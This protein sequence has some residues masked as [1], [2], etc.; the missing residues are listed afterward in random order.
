[1]RTLFA[2]LILSVPLSAQAP[3]RATIGERIAPFVDEQTLVVM[4]FDISKLEVESLLKLASAFGEPDLVSEVAP[5]MRKLA[6]TF[7]KKGG[8]EIFVTYGAGDY[9]AFPAICVPIGDSPPTRKDLGELVIELVDGVAPKLVIDHIHGCVCVGTTETMAMV[10]A[11]KAV[12]RPELMEAI[13]NGAD[14]P[15]QFAFALSADARRVHEEVAPMLPGELGG[16]SIH[17]VTRGAKWASLAINP[18]PKMPARF[19]V[20]AISPAAAQELLDLST[21]GRDW[22]IGAAIRNAFGRLEPKKTGEL[23]TSTKARVTGRQVVVEWDIISEAIASGKS[24]D[25]P[26]A[27]RLQSANNMKQMMIALHNFHDVNTR[28]PVNIVDKSGKPL[29]SWRVAILPYIDHEALY[30]EF[31]L[32]EPWDSEHNKKLLA[33]MPRMYR[34]PKQAGALK[35]RTTYL[36]PVGQGTLWDVPA[37]AKIA[38]ILDGTSNTIAVVEADDDKAVEWTRPQDLPVTAKSPFNGLLGHYGEGIHVAIA[39]GSIRFIRKS[40]DPKV[41]WALFTRAGGEVID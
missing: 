7:V 8:R 13:A 32:D 11:R 15:I 28:F 10:K 6:E 38:D 40:V 4:R 18:G 37:G 33:R 2:M 23:L 3:A 19:T 12:A 27:G 22:A 5:T 20:E 24:I 17:K 25:G 36:A 16:G 26:D 14:A 34:S 41:L 1:M 29:L 31:K 30:K 39:D 9:P 21:K 35:D